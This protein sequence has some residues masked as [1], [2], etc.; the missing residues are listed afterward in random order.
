MGFGDRETTVQILTKTIIWPWPSDNTFLELSSL[1]DKMW[2]R[3]STLHGAD[4]KMLLT[5]A[6]NIGV[7]K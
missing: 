1:I 7:L 5:V 4:C 2:T 6:D 3:R